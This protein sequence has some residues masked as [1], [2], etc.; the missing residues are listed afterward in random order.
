MAFFG[1]EVVDL[2][3][4]FSLSPDY[5]RGMCHRIYVHIV[6]TTRDRAPLIDAALARFLCRILRVL[7][8]KEHSIVLEVGIV[9]THLHVLVRIH[10]T[11]SLT[12][13]VKRMKGASSVLAAREGYAVQGARLYWAKGYSVHSVGVRNLER[14]R[15]YLRAQPLHHPAEALAD[16]EGDTAAEYDTGSM[17]ALI[18][19]QQSSD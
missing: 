7:A 18:T 13:L 16:W 1:A 2:D 14:V 11:T 6:W 19:D 10:P 3:G 15:T 9:S 5:S 4:L 8:R 17:D 12:S